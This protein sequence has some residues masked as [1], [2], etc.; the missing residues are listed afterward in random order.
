ME[1]S[2]V[3]DSMKKN[4]EQPIANRSKAAA[5]KQKRWKTIKKTQNLWLIQGSQASYVTNPR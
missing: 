2:N 1:N 4:V 5:N 3:L